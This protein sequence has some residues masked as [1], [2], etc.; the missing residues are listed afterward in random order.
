MASFRTCS[1]A[2]NI[3]RQIGEAAFFYEYEAIVVPN[4]RWPTSNVVVMTEHASVT[5]LIAD[6]GEI[7]DLAAWR[8]PPPFQMKKGR[9]SP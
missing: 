9:V 7:V 3:R 8:F 5:Q 2:E 4:A 6:E 1:G